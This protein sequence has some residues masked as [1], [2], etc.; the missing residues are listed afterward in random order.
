MQEDERD[1]E[2]PAYLL[3]NS[4]FSHRLLLPSLIK[5]RQGL[6]AALWH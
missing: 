5:V 1:T 2:L 3:T 6:W 4:K